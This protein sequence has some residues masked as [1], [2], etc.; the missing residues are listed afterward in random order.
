MILADK[1]AD[2]HVLAAAIVSLRGELGLTQEDAAARLGCAAGHM[3]L[4]EAGGGSLA[5][6]AHVLAGLAAM[7]GLRLVRRAGR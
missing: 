5:E 6:Q 4:Y 1:P 2:P 3:A 7:L